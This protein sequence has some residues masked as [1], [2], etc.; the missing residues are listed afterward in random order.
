[1]AGI[2]TCQVGTLA[3]DADPFTV[4]VSGPTDAAD[5][6]QLLNL[7]RV[8]ASN[9]PDAN[10]GNNED[11]ATV[12]V[13]CALIEVTKTADAASVSAGDPIGF[14][15]T[16]RNAGAGTAYMVTASDTL[17]G[18]YTWSIAAPSAGWTLVGNQLSYAAATLA[19]GASSSVHVTA[20][21][22]ADL[23]GLVPNS[24]TASAGND[25]TDTATAQTQVLCPDV[26]IEKTADNSP[27]L[28]GQ[29]AS[30]EISVSNE[31]PGTAYD[32]VITDTLP[33]GLTWTE[34]SEDCSIAAGVLT[35]QVGTLTPTDEPFT[36]TVSAPTTVAACGDLPNLAEVS[37]S[38]EPDSAT[39]NNSDDATI[40]VQCA[41]IS[42]VKTAGTAAD[43]ATLVVAKPGNVVFTY[44]VTNTGTADLMDISL[45]DDNATPANTGDDITVICP[46]L[47][48]AAGA[49]MTC[50]ATLPVTY[51]LRT[52]IATVTAVPELEPEAEVVRHRRRGRP[53]AAAGEDSAPDAEDHPAADV[54]PRHHRDPDQ[55]RQRP[56]PGPPV[57]RRVPAGHRVPHPEPGA[58]PPA[59]P[60]GVAPTEAGAGD[61]GPGGSASTLGSP[62][63]GRDAQ[64]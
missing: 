53:G 2:L 42:L 23:C 64:A 40:D 7:A 21:T 10:Q 36:V 45:V 26:T 35:C 56:A 60:P 51:G 17:N 54:L 48:L 18:A 43:G 14:T 47:T 12:V 49:S 62:R 15:I 52:N 44:V 31:G 38:N 61:A 28:A 46:S 4:T 22:T 16:V 24:V 25:G 6:G 33:A 58:L 41:S 8:D 13:D 3:D 9:E 63:P 30:F 50:T 19:P 37:A 27:I 34:S 39:E 5:C 55:R 1:M 32:V 11:D 57:P 29:A 20:P 59:E